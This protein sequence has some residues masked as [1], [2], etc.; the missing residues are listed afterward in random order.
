MSMPVIIF[1]SSP[2]RWLAVP[3]PADAYVTAAGFAFASAI[4]VF[5]EV[6]GSEGWTTSMFAADVHRITGAK[7]FIG[8]NGKLR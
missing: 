5:T 6:A 4:N 1:R 3:L 8:S 2:A 7:S